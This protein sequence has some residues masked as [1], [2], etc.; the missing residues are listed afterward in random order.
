MPS[1]S[2][3]PGML[4]RVREDD[5]TRLGVARAT[6]LLDVLFAGVA[7]VGVVLGG[8]VRGAADRDVAAVA[9]GAVAR[10]DVDGV[11]R[12]AMAHSV[13][14][15]INEPSHS[16]TRVEGSWTVKPPERSVRSSAAAGT[17]R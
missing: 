13:E 10:R 16:R 4:F 2:S 17:R 6:G 12:R 3:G 8:V 9:F 1:T 14:E 11:E 7:R 15:I 5:R